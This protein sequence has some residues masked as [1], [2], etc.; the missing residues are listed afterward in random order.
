MR[1]SR[2]KFV[3]FGF[4]IGISSIAPGNW[5]AS[6]FGQ[7]KR[8]RPVRPTDPLVYF[9]KSTFA[10]YANT[11]FQIVN[12]VTRPVSL[13]LSVVEDL[14][15]SKALQAPDECFGLLFTAP[16]GTVLSQGTYQ[17]EHGALGTFALFL[18]PVG[19]TRP[20]GPVQYQAV[21]YRRQFTNDLHRTAT[22]N[23]EKSVI[24][25]VWE[26]QRSR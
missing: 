22:A 1:I 14:P 20:D 13:R 8:I 2:R 19:K 10:A 25:N 9:N 3:R 15:G 4:A 21:F 26:L 11:E 16:F 12:G 24:A 6:A 17:V 23:S 7:K 18:V 5:L